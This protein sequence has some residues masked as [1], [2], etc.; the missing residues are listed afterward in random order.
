MF[1]NLNQTRT[2]VLDDVINPCPSELDNGFSIYCD[3][4]NKFHLKFT[5]VNDVTRMN[6]LNYEDTLQYQLY[7]FLTK[8]EQQVLVQ[9]GK[10][11]RSSI[12]ENKLTVPIWISR[13]SFPDGLVIWNN[14]KILKFIYFKDLLV[15]LNDWLRLFQPNVNDF[16]CVNKSKDL[17]FYDIKAYNP[18]LNQITTI[19]LYSP[20]LD[21][22][23]SQ[24]NHKEF[25]Y[26]YNKVKMICPFCFKFEFEFI[27]TSG[28][29]RYMFFKESEEEDIEIDIVKF[30]E[31]NGTNLENTWQD[32]PDVNI[33]W[34][35][36]V[37]VSSLVN[38]S[39]FEFLLM[40]DKNRKV[41]FVAFEDDNYKVHVNCRDIM[42]KD[43]IE[44]SIKPRYI[45]ND[46]FYQNL[47][48]ELEDRANIFSVGDYIS[49][50]FNTEDINEVR[51]I[52]VA[53]EDCGCKEFDCNNIIKENRVKFKSDLILNEQDSVE[54]IVKHDLDIR[55]NEFVDWYIPG[56]DKRGSHRIFKLRKSEDE[57]RFNLYIEDFTNQ[58]VNKIW[59]FGY[60]GVSYYY[61]YFPINILGSEIYKVINE[62]LQVNDFPIDSFIDK[63][64]LLLVDKEANRTEHFEL[65]FNSSKRSRLEYIK[66]NG[67]EMKPITYN[68]VDKPRLSDTFNFNYSEF[69]G[70]GNGTL[71][72]LHKND[73]KEDRKDLLIQKGIDLEE[74]KTYLVFNDNEY[75]TNFFIDNTLHTDYIGIITDMKIPSNE[76]DLKICYK[77]YPKL[78]KIGKYI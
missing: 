51:F 3:L 39:D 25:L 69:S 21:L 66:V 49:I 32:V 64:A 12:T 26:I 73:W 20:R 48:L 77:F 4:S 36:P 5:N 40:K 35:T 60:S 46:S 70:Y 16:Y 57:T 7:N 37:T 50:R 1:F 42:G 62:F 58:M 9:K 19:P 6:Q 33:D 34:V 78:S 61:H 63:G 67:N 24:V 17:N 13:N 44:N 72:I 74:L 2:K 31:L 68:F 55:E 18:A 10:N 15:L 65:W 52:A 47:K 41:Y 54:V 22:D 29:N 53:N 38:K 8:A 59:E 71:L 76:K 30:N 11:M 45:L 27:E 14:D 56:L 75:H 28:E 23:H 43:S